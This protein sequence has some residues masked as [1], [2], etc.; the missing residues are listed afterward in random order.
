MGFVV[1]ILIW[2][3]C[4]GRNSRKVYRKVEN[5]FPSIITALIII[6]ALG[7]ILPAIL[8]TS[9]VVLG[10]GLGI[11][12]VILIIAL[13]LRTTVGAKGLE[14]DTGGKSTVR[15][16]DRSVPTYDTSGLSK[17]V[18]KRKKIITKFNKKYSLNLTD[19]EV[20]RII[21]ASYVSDFW[22]SEVAAMN[23]DYMSVSSW[24]KGRTSWFR[25]YVRS[26]PLQSIS[27][28]EELQKAHCLQSFNEVF[29]F[30]ESGN[31]ASVDECI[32][33]INNRYLTNFDEAGFMVAY[34]FLEENGRK[35][36]L[37]GVNLIKNLSPLEELQQ[38]YDSMEKSKVRR[39][40]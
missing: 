19:E 32:D 17:A 28:D 1:L 33:A 2:Y 18:P 5:H 9:L 12:L 16:V 14:E 40:N 27:S 4:S 29:D 22:A 38:K 30:V 34:R 11:G 35:I 37:P 39:V 21:D 8:I 24:Y 10:S 13:L 6:G 25:V 31:Y 7:S 36:E 23:K 15:R 20:E 26:F 3:Y